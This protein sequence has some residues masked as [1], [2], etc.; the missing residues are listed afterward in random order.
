MN[1]SSERTRKEAI[2]RAEAKILA[3]QADDAR[4]AAKLTNWD[5]MRAEWDQLQAE[6]VLTDQERLLNVADAVAKTFIPDLSPSADATAAKVREI[7]TDAATSIRCTVTRDLGG[8]G[9]G[10]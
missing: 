10:T 4:E 5:R 1:T 3:E 9:R 7:L 6:A 2:E 8:N